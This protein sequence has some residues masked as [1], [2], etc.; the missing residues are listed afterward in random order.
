MS[1][2]TAAVTLAC[3]C[4][5]EQLT[6]RNGCWVKQVQSRSGD[7]HETI[8]GCEPHAASWS[9]DPV[10]RAAEDCLYYVQQERYSSN[11]SGELDHADWDAMAKQCLTEAEKVALQQIERLRGQ[12]EGAQALATR[13]ERDNA[14]LRKTLVACVEKTPAAVANATATTESKSDAAGRPASTESSSSSRHTVHAVTHHG[15][16]TPPLALRAGGV[17]AHAS[18]ASCDCSTP[19][20]AHHAP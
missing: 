20:S 18:P 4:V 19:A 7:L 1:V 12:L 9:P 8:A 17:E 10:V 6:Q 3:G 5:H 13:M 15:A 14:E 16:P 11:A 2:F